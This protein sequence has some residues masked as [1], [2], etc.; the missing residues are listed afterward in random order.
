[1]LFKLNAQGFKGVENDV[2]YWPF[3]KQIDCVLHICQTSICVLH[4]GS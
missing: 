4:M 2:Y 3:S 1:M